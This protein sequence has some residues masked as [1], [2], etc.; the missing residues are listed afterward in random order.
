MRVSARAFITVEAGQV[1]EP[2]EV[3]VDIALRAWLG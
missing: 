2:S 1:A 3:D